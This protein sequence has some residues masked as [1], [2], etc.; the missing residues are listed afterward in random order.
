VTIL[1]AK[2]GGDFRWKEVLLQ[3]VALA[4]GSYL[5]FVVLLKLQMAIWP[6]FSTA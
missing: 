1:A 2:A 3:A 4:L 6:A 5:V